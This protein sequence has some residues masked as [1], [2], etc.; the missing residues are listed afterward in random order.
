MR[1]ETR[2]SAGERQ[3]T[4]VARSFGMALDNGS[5]H[6]AYGHSSVWEEQ[7][8]CTWVLVIRM[9]CCVGRATASGTS[10]THKPGR[11]CASRWSGSFG[12]LRCSC[13][14][15]GCACAGGLQHGIAPLSQSMTECGSARVAPELIGVPALLWHWRTFYAHHS[16][17]RLSIRPSNATRVGID[18]QA[19]IQVGVDRG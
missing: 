8:L 6:G 17:G 19:I 1:L 14:A 16:V 12:G 10:C 11:H 3:K 5:V 9:T 13:H 2:C 18:C 15:R 4:T 7:R